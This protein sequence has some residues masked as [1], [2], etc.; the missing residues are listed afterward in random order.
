MS[1]TAMTMKVGEVMPTAGTV[2]YYDRNFFMEGSFPWPVW[3]QCVTQHEPVIRGGEP[4]QTGRAGWVVGPAAFG[5]VMV[6]TE[7]MVAVQ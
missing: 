3:E 5:L 1:L 7:A 2:V 4:C 6:E